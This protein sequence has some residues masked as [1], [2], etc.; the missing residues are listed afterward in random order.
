MGIFDLSFLLAILRILVDA[1]FSDPSSSVLP[2]VTWPPSHHSLHK[3]N[4]KRF[5]NT[6]QPGEKSLQI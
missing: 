3:E 4:E 1:L 5:D 6:F 2:P